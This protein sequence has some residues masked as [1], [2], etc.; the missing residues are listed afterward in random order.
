M[1]GTKGLRGTS[2][3]LRDALAT[4]IV[5]ARKMRQDAFRV[6]A[7]VFAERLVTDDAPSAGPQELHAGA[8]LAVCL[9]VD[10]GDRWDDL[11]PRKAASVVMEVADFLVSSGACAPMDAVC[12]LDAGGVS[13]R[14]PSPLGGDL[15][16]LGV[17]GGVVLAVDSQRISLIA[18][19]NMEVRQQICAAIGDRGDFGHRFRCRRT[20]SRM[21]LGDVSRALAAD[22][23]PPSWS[24]ADMAIWESGRWTPSAEAV[25]RLSQLPTF[26]GMDVGFLQ[27]WTVSAAATAHAAAAAEAEAKKAPTP[28]ATP[29][30]TPIAASVAATDT[31]DDEYV[32]GDDDAGEARRRLTTDRVRTYEAM[33]LVPGADAVGGCDLLD[34]VVFC[35]ISESPGVYSESGVFRLVGLAPGVGGS[36]TLVLYRRPWR[37]DEAQPPSVRWRTYR[38]LGR[39]TGAALFRG[40]PTDDDTLLRCIDGL[41]VTPFGTCLRRRRLDRGWT[42]PDLAA[43]AAAGSPAAEWWLK[44][45]A[46]WESGGCAAPH[47][48]SSMFRRLAGVFAGEGE[49]TPDDMQAWKEALI[50]MGPSRPSPAVQLARDAESRLRAEE[51]CAA[52][53]G[54]P[55]WLYGSPTSAAPAESPAPAPVTV[56]VTVRSVSPS[57]LMVPTRPSVAE[58]VMAF[59]GPYRPSGR[60][61]RRTVV[62]EMRLV[63]PEGTLEARTLLRMVDACDGVHRAAGRVFSAKPA[64]GMGFYAHR[65]FLDACG[66]ADD[67]AGFLRAVGDVI[68]DFTLLVAPPERR[69]PLPDN[70]VLVWRD[71]DDVMWVEM[72]SDAGAPV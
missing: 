20:A 29:I 51:D 66:M 56:S 44:M 11:S 60:D 36:E 7:T 55:T 32:P 23:D 9:H 35:T 53:G 14:T 4:L 72:V 63:V 52:Y 5:R 64:F 50:S 42:L 46:G 33:S 41:R 39:V 10:A 24:A 2:R 6:S 8:R 18:A 1:S 22:G 16:V 67:R 13:V 43:R 61:A 48:A 15:R 27:A 25:A 68:S 26:R 34:D 47:A 28:V 58:A 49:V 54:F 40:K 21:T 19:E 62:R 45:L 31:I 38:C 69:P 37:R 3:G 30:A 65:A 57:M 12:A 70:V 17:V 59:L 71:I